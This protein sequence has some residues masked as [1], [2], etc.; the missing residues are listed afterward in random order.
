VK[1]EDAIIFEPVS[2]PEDWLES[3]TDLSLPDLRAKLSRFETDPANFWG[4]L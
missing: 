1:G 2:L 3:L 4:Q